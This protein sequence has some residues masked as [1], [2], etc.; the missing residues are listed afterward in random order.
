[1]SGYAKIAVLLVAMIA[2]FA[3]GVKWEIG[4]VAARDL[5]ASAAQQAQ[6]M[7]QETE[8][9]RMESLRAGKVIEAQN[10]Q[11]KRTQTL[12]A[13]AAGAR[14][15]SAGLRDDIAAIRASLPSTPGDASGNAAST[16]A[17]LLA[18][19]AAAYQGLAAAA[20]GHYSDTLTLQQA[21][22]K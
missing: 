2:A 16:A 9:R 6:A 7:A 11:A 19:C 21:W 8:N 15:E 12:Q 20:D 3:A 13:A 18:E 10:A 17:G 5:K 4:I 14:T 22:P 1:M